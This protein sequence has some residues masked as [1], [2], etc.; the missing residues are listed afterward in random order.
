MDAITDVE[1]IKA[2]AH[3]QAKYAKL[4]C[5]AFLGED[6]DS[7]FHPKF[8]WFRHSSSIVSIVGSGNLTAGGL[9][10]NC[11]AFCVSKLSPREAVGWESKWSSWM[12]E[13]RAEL[14][15]IDDPRVSKRAEENRRIKRLLKRRQDESVSE[16]DEGDLIVGPPKGAQAKVLVAEIPRGGPRWQQGNFNLETFNEFFGAAPG[17]TQR[18]LLGHLS[19]DGVRGSVE[20]RPSIASHS[21][22]YRFELDAGAGLEYPATGRPIAVFVRIATRT[23]RY[24]LLMPG[25]PGFTQARAYLQKEIGASP[26]RMRRHITTWQHIRGQVF[27]RGLAE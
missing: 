11:E 23:F 12:R 9:R 6:G 8:S 20:E 22:N 25:T 2:L 13:R 17:R 7:I 3:F 1:A 26:H 24:R 14:L 16:T 21:Q 19:I 15:A 27:A 10:S 4:S 18:I 5:K